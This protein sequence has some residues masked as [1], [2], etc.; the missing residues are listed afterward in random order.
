MVGSSLGSVS[1]IALVSLCLR[2]DSDGSPRMGDAAAAED[3]SP[4]QRA[5]FYGR[6]R[7]CDSWSLD[8]CQTLLICDV[9]LVVTGELLVLALY[10]VKFQPLPISP[11]FLE[12]PIL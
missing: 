2:E 8:L 9:S 4:S 7:C 12:F 1:G 10:W 6:R 5:R 3:L 11:P